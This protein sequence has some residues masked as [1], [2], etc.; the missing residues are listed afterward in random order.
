MIKGKEYSELL[1]QIS[2]HAGSLVEVEEFARKAM[3]KYNH[4]PLECFHG[5]SPTQ[6]MALMQDP[7]HSGQ[8]PI[9]C[10][11]VSDEEAS[12]IPLVQML[13]TALQ[14]FSGEQGEKLTPQ[15]RWPLRLLLEM[16]EYSSRI[17]G[18]HFPFKPRLEEDLPPAMALR[19][20]LEMDGMMRKLKGRVLLT[21]KGHTLLA[22]GAAQQL[23]WLQEVFVMRFN[24]A[25]LD[26]H[27]EL[28]HL[29]TGWGFMIWLLL[30]YGQ[31]K[32]SMDFYVQAFLQAWPGVFEM[33]AG[34]AYW[35]AEQAFASVFQT[36]M[37]ERWLLWMGS[38]VMEQEGKYPDSRVLI[39]ATPLLQ[40]CWAVNVAATE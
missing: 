23:A 17:A 10:R 30:H 29:Q 25:C 34:S 19:A 27:E 33:R 36:R 21:R 31:E 16:Y 40:T 22:A 1:R 7:F 18:S 12:V 4:T 14:Y 35:T 26:G 37:L 24:W 8:S 20:L 11:P 9:V 38:V 39:H 15:G 3:E 28:P 5:L 2:E 13:E 32:R 6:M